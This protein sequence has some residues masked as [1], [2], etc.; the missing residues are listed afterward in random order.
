MTGGEIGERVNVLRR[1]MLSKKTLELTLTK[2]DCLDFRP[3]Q[4]VR[5][6]SRGIERDYTPVS[7]PEQTR[8]ILLIRIF[9][10][11]ELTPRLAAVREGESLHV[12]GPHGYFTFRESPRP[13]VFVATG[14]GIAPF[15]SMARAGV[16]GF[17]LFQGAAAAEELY[18][19]TEMEEAAERCYPCVS[20][21]GSRN[22]VHSRPPGDSILAG[23][24]T[25]HI[26][27]TLPP[28]SYDFYLCGNGKMIE[29]VT[30]IIDEK[31]SGSRVYTEIFY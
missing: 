7:S 24:V 17:I 9:E 16:S 30:H 22:G 10:E 5:I 27:G 13:A 8:L 4:R 31:F 26:E 19:R 6:I 11:G 3:G 14:T 21:G 29:K 18:Y 1:D 20:S 15:V 2:P 12:T 25:D 23:R 28:G